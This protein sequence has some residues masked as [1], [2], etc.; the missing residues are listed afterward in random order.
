MKIQD[1]KVLKTRLKSFSAILTSTLKTPTV[2]RTEKL[3]NIKTYFINLKTFYENASYCTVDLFDQSHSP[4]N[5]NANI[6]N[7]WM[8]NKLKMFVNFRSPLRTA[9]VA[10][11]TWSPASRSRSTAPANTSSSCW[12]NAKSFTGWDTS[13]RRSCDSWKRPCCADST[14]T[15]SSL[16]FSWLKTDKRSTLPKDIHPDWRSLPG[17]EDEHKPVLNECYFRLIETRWRYLTAEKSESHT[18]FW[19][20]SWRPSMITKQL[21]E[22]P[23]TFS[24]FKAKPT[25]MWYIKNNWKKLNANKNIPVFFSY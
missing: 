24:P 13:G 12:P 25:R 2:N 4:R 9:V 20:F 18:A 6:I 8:Q 17:R 10:N 21:E 22:F 1:R 14:R 15:P 5:G 19:R 11:S 7:V 23:K 3:S 16:R